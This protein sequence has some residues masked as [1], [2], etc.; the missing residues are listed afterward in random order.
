MR[1]LFV[2]MSEEK[3]KHSAVIYYAWNLV[4]SV[5]CSYKYLSEKTQNK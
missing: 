4:N 5:Q 1:I 2:G 3:K